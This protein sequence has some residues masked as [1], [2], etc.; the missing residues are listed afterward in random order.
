MISRLFNKIHVE[1]TL[2]VAHECVH[3]LEARD[4]WHVRE[5]AIAENLLCV[6]KHLEV[7]WSAKGQYTSLSADDID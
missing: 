6:A 1:I 4:I 7:L 3:L 2:I 5:S